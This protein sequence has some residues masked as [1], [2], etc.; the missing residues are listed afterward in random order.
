MGTGPICVPRRESPVWSGGVGVLAKH[1]SDLPLHQ[2]GRR[3]Y[4]SLL[5]WAGGTCV[6]SAEQTIA[7]PS[8]VRALSQCA[9]KWASFS[10]KA[11]AASCELLDTE[12]PALGIGD[13]INHVWEAVKEETATNIFIVALIYMD[14]MATQGEDYRNVLCRNNMHK[15]FL[16]SVTLAN[17]FLEEVA[18]CNQSWAKIGGISLACLNA[19]ELEALQ[20]LG[21][22]LMVQPEVFKSYAAQLRCG[23]ARQQEIRGEAPLA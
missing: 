4:Q 5:E 23:A 19:L 16:V 12:A 7:A 22:N 1:S 14:R 10:R 2:E 20:L 11:P 13:Y 9:T 21:F 6:P 18:I 17:K 8:D 15:M 3:V